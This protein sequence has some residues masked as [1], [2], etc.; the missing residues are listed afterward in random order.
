MSALRDKNTIMDTL[1]DA[2]YNNSQRWTRVTHV[3]DGQFSLAY[4]HFNNELVQ[5]Y[6]VKLVTHWQKTNIERY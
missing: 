4:K 2:D 5:I 1:D 3:I 6:C